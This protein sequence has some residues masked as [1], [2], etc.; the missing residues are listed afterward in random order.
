MQSDFSEERLTLRIE[1]LSDLKPFTEDADVAR[2][3]VERS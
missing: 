3:R 2:K 1:G